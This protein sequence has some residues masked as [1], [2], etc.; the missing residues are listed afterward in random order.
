M[1][2]ES[3]LARGALSLAIRGRRYPVLLPSVR[4]PRMRLTAVI[5][6]LQILGQT[7]LG[8]QVSIAQ[9]LLALVTAMTFVFWQRRVI[10]WPARALIAGT[11]AAFILR[12]PGTAHGD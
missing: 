2:A 3:A 10:M 9:I 1:A 12:V 4:D 8:F 11:G 7:S 5:W 6:S